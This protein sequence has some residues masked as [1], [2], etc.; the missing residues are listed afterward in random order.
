[1][2]ELISV[3]EK[4]EGQKPGLLSQDNQFSFLLLFTLVDEDLNCAQMICNK[5][6]ASFF[7]V[8]FHTIIIL[9]IYFF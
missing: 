9:F 4:F 2:E 3:H 5:S 6:L 8:I 7:S 1:M